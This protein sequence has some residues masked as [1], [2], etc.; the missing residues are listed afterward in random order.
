MPVY[1]AQSGENGPVKIG[2]CKD[3]AEKRISVLQTGCPDELHILYVVEI[4]ARNFEGFLHKR[5]QKHRLRGEWFIYSQEIKDFIA[6]DVRREKEKY[7]RK[8]QKQEVRIERKQEERENLERQK[9]EDQ[10]WE[11][12]E[13]AEYEKYLAEARAFA[14]EEQECPQE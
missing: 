8:K 11:K 2:W 13:E 10:E 7:R 4:C 5:F 3:A 12:Y 6:W 1:F 14:E 9:Y